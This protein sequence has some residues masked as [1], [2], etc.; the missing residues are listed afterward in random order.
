[1]KKLYL[2]QG[3]IFQNDHVLGI[4]Y[5]PDIGTAVTIQKAMLYAV[6]NGV[7]GPLNEEGDYGGEMNDKWGESSITNFKISDTELSFTKQYKN[8][9]PIEYLFDEKEGSTW[10]GTYQGQDCGTD[11]SKCFVTEIDESFFERNR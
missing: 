9:P 10:I 1:M 6:F 4:G 7:I 11:D 2:I 3:I 5:K 8:R